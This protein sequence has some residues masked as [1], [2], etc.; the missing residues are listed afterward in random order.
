MHQLIMLFETRVV[1]SV[2]SA[3]ALLGRGCMCIHMVGLGTS[4][5]SYAPPHHT[6]PLVWLWLRHHRGK[7][8]KLA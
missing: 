4:P 8:R 1:V 5:Q 6:T 7:A 3:V 2:S